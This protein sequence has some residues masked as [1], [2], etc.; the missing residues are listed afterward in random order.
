MLI[1]IHLSNGLSFTK[2]IY[3]GGNIKKDEYKGLTLV[4]TI[5]VSKGVQV[6]SICTNG[7]PEH[8]IDA[9]VQNLCLTQAPMYLI[10]M[11]II[12]L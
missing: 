7:E 2:K 3:T 1:F 10:L 8:W 12:N 11:V 6:H 5:G 9:V 4:I